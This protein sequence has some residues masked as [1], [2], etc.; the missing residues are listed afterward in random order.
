MVAYM[1]RRFYV[2]S[3][4][5]LVLVLAV[6]VTGLQANLTSGSKAPDFKL[7]D[8]DGKEK[9]FADIQKDPKKKG[10]N[11]V[12]LLD[13]WATW[14]PPCRAEVP[15]LQKL[16]EKY[17]KKGLVIVGVA[18]DSDGAKA[19]KPFAAKNKL[20]YVNLVDPKHEVARKYKVGPIPTTY[21]ID[22]KGV[23]RY[24]HLGFAPG[25]EKDLEEEIKALL[26]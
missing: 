10:A 14:C 3:G 11:R 8:L 26:K 1:R 16:H 2:V 24:V 25:M 19:V 13:F 7:R 23:I 9:K 18:Q 21:L 20:T 5:L 15:H 4:L 17:G 12:V 6:A 22:R